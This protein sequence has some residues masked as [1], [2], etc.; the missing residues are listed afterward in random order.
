[1]LKL[2]KGL[3]VLGPLLVLIENKDHRA[4]PSTSK[5]GIFIV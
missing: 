3:E 5:D 1:M 4:P 2:G